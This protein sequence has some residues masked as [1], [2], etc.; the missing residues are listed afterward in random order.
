MSIIVIDV[1]HPQN[2]A[3]EASLV[4]LAI[5]L[6]SF[7]DIQCSSVILICIIE[8][9]LLFESEKNIL[10]MINFQNPNVSSTCFEK[11]TA[12]VQVTYFKIP[13]KSAKVAM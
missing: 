10:F 11:R 7:I 4:T 9:V 5:F 2:V 6:Y 12:Y 8:M 13:N 1:S 3:L